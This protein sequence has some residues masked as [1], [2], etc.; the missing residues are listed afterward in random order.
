MGLV[1][2][3][4]SCDIKNYAFSIPTLIFPFLCND[5]FWLNV[6]KFCAR[7]ESKRVIVDLLKSQ[8]QTPTLKRKFSVAYSERLTVASVKYRE[9]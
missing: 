8:I 4:V 6:K 9:A 2:V 7:R 1:D 3:S 5:F